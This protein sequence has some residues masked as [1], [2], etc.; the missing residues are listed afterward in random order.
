MRPPLSAVT[1]MESV[2]IAGE[3]PVLAGARLG[4]AFGNGRWRGRISKRRARPFELYW[5]VEI[6]FERPKQLKISMEALFF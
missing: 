2:G 6:Q 3:R 5:Q 4:R 1:G